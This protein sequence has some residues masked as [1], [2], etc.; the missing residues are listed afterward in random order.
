MTNV[1]P[2][3][4][5]G[6]LKTTVDPKRY[7]T[8]PPNQYSVPTFSKRVDVVGN[9]II[10]DDALLSYE[11]VPTQSGLIVW[12][13][14]Q[15]VQTVY[16]FGY[17][18]AGTDSYGAAQSGLVPP[19][20]FPIGPDYGPIRYNKILALPYNNIVASDVLVVTPVM[21]TDTIS[22]ARLYAGRLRVQS[23]TLAISQVQFGGYLTGTA[24]GDVRSIFNADVTDSYSTANMV[25]VATT[26]N[27]A[28]KEVSVTKGIVSLVGPD[29]A[30]CFSKPNADK[31][32][33]FSPGQQYKPDR[34]TGMVTAATAA[35]HLGLASGQSY[36]QYA[37]W[38]T[39]WDVTIDMPSIT[40]EGW[41][42]QNIKKGSGNN[43]GINPFGGC[44]DVS[45]QF[46]VNRAFSPAIPGLGYQE[47]WTVEIASTYAT[48]SSDGG[49]YYTTVKE[50]TDCGAGTNANGIPPHSGYHT[51]ACTAH[52][53]PR[54][55]A[56]GGF[57]SSTAAGYV[58]NG[59]DSCY[60]N[61][62]NMGMYLGSLI[63]IHAT[64]V[65]SMAGV[66]G[67]MG[68]I[69]PGPPT[70][71]PGPPPVTS[72]GY[73]NIISCR[74]NDD[75]APGEL[76]P[77]RAIRYDGMVKDSLL[78][79]DGLFMAECVPG[80][81]T[82]PFTQSGETMSHVCENANAMSFLSFAYN[83][84][85]S[86]FQRTY[87]GDEYDNFVRSVIP[88]MGTRQLRQFANQGFV[89]AAAAA[90]ILNEPTCET[91]ENETGTVVQPASIKR[92]RAQTVVEDD[93]MSLY[94]GIR[95][96]GPAIR[97]YVQSAIPP[98]IPGNTSQRL[99][100]LDSMMAPIERERAKQ[101]ASYAQ[102]GMK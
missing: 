9:I 87:A 26:V 59:P 63:V 28:V 22:V 62:Q 64:N 100:N 3:T 15:G 32:E 102:M 25:Q 98:G 38:V 71:D 33:S 58:G 37:G 93:K 60:T 52:S 21:Q 75:G 16:R 47:Q 34:M 6:L 27:D 19:S 90:G 61:I 18:A 56:T 36:R 2:C 5:M 92:P 40:P 20:G 50:Y 31:S 10:K 54:M 1:V 79:V 45:V 44:L 78:R 76:G 101:Q 97:D 72:N 30:P 67:S 53:N 77:C 17:V 69:A 35:A 51:F 88:V 66:A 24:T 85:E 83:T 65:G 73:F 41:T 29:I 8:L 74:S 11:K 49:I 91:L 23:D 57:S 55:R 95:S 7:N 48:V 94:D 4:G 14:S 12:M 96:I 68:Y 99:S 82:A 43:G 13:P 84:P 46:Y 39:P 81:I 80:Y 42:M 70:I 89:R 86:P